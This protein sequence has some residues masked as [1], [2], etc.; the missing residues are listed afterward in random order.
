MKTVRFKP[1]DVLKP[2][3]RKQ[4]LTKA[5]LLQACGCSAMTAWRIL[6]QQGYLTSYNHNAK[7]YTLVRSAQFDEQGLWAYRD[8]RFSK[9]GTLPD[10]ILGQVERSAAG[11]TARELEELLHVSNVKP[12]LTHLSSQGRLQRAKMAGAMVYFAGQPLRHQQQLQR[13]ETEAAAR[14]ALQALPDPQHV[15]ALLVEI[16]RHPRQ[17]PRQWARRLAQQGIRLRT[18]EIQAVLDH[19]QLSV[20]KGLSS[21]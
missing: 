6:H 13:R 8:I 5:E 3:S 11:M 10:T 21:S 20:K 4:V 17:T 1:G 12:T 2:F 7:Y 14:R 15:I 19:Y 18:A 16:I 9:W